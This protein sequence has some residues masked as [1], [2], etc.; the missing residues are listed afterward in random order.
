M[1]EKNSCITNQI[2]EERQVSFMCQHRKTSLDWYIFRV[3]FHCLTLFIAG[4]RRGNWNI[5]VSFLTLFSLLGIIYWWCVTFEEGFCDTYLNLLPR[6]ICVT[7]WK[8]VFPQLIVQTQNNTKTI[9][10]DSFKLM[11]FFCQL[12]LKSNRNI[13]WCFAAMTLKLNAGNWRDFFVAEYN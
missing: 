10:I 3:A 13:S 9:A 7:N 12:N 5:D 1:L 4:K 8:K 2:Q 11:K 6:Q